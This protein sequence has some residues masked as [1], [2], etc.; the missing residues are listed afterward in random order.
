[1]LQ[2]IDDEGRAIYVRD[3]DSSDWMVTEEFINIFESVNLVTKDE[4]GRSR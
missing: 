2:L 1:M 3:E 4:G